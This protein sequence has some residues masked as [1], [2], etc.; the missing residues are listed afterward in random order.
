MLEAPLPP[1]VSS[2]SMT[3]SDK[4]IAALS[5]AN[6]VGGATGDN[7]PQHHYECIPEYLLTMSR[8]SHSHPHYPP[9]IVCH[10][11]CSLH[12]RPSRCSAPYATFSRSLQLSRRVTTATT[13]T[14]TSTSD[15]SQCT[16]SPPP[17]TAV[18]QEESSTPLISS[19]MH[20]E[21]DHKTEKSLISSPKS[22]MIGWTRRNSSNS[23][24]RKSID[25]HRNEQR[26][27]FLSQLRKSSLL[28]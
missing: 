18:A 7:S 14:T 1:I 5:T 8:H 22:M 16:C 24:K 25:N 10:Y 27:S 13:T 28:K 17:S 26:H 21:S 4:N 23:T 20:Q 6:S 19:S 2:H 9:S 3:N 11:P 12:Y 15:S